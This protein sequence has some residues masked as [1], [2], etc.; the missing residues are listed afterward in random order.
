MAFK[1]ALKNKK[2]YIFAGVLTF[3]GFLPIIIEAILNIPAF[4]SGNGD[5]YIYATGLIASVY[6][7]VGFIWA[8]LYSANIRKKTK[9]WDGKLSEDTLVAIWHRRIPWWL[10]TIAVAILLAVLSIIYAITGHYPFA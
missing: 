2:N 5:L 1:L 10:A 9:N 3:I 8:D 4:N 7:L 6:F